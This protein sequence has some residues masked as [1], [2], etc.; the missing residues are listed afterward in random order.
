MAKRSNKAANATIAR[1]SIPATGV[2]ASREITA[3]I[4]TI[5]E[6]KINVPAVFFITHLL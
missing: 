2:S 4:L 1:D 6:I 3:I 5:A